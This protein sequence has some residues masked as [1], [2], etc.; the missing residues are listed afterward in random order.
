FEDACDA[1]AERGRAEGER[2]W[3]RWF[4]RACG[5]VDRTCERAE[6][7]APAGLCGRAL[8]A[9]LQQALQPAATG[10][11]RSFLRTPSMASTSALAH[12]LASFAPSSSLVIPAVAKGGR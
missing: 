8:P 5:L 6:A 11:G 7:L 4:D 12:A 2:L 10:V 1:A 3:D 9:P